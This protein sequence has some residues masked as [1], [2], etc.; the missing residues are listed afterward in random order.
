[1]R[2]NRVVIALLWITLALAAC[3]GARA[4]PATPAPAATPPIGGLRAAS[5]LTL[6]MLKATP[7]LPWLLGMDAP[8]TY[9]ILVQNNDEL[10]ATGGFLSAVGTLGIDR[11]RPGDV[12]FVDSYTVARDDVEHPWAPDPMRKY[13]GIDLMFVRDANWSPDLP[14]TGQ[15]VKALY[16]QDAGVLV[17]G[18][19]T[20][21]MN[22]V[23]LL[24]DALGPLQIEG[25]DEPITGDNLIEQVVQ[26]WDRPVETGTIAEAGLENWWQQRKDFMP[27]LAKAALERLR[28]GDVSPL[29]LAA[30]A[31]QA[32]D[33]RSI[34]VWIDD[35]VV[36]D[37]LAD[38]YWDGAIAPAAG[39]DFLALVDTNVGYNKVDAV[40][41]RSLDYRVTWPDGSAAPAVAQATVT[42]RHPIQ[43]PGY[44]C[45]PSPRYGDN[46]E[47]MTRR[48]Y[49]DYVRLY[50]PAGSE[51]IAVDG[52]ASDSVTSER[53]DHNTQVF[54]GYF[55]L[56]PGY[57][58]SVQFTYRL[59]PEIT[60][61]DY[62][63]VVQRQ[64]GLEALP[65]TLTAGEE[66]LATEMATSRLEWSP[67][68]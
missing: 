10:R 54:G 44:V 9:L 25:A 53:A 55:T 63:L 11:G 39:S 24:I 52:V 48:C 8:R 64:S 19:I 59:P 30:A 41:D 42:Y 31:Y 5:R 26:F 20:I 37:I 21:D 40:L 7:K 56:L 33:Q 65:V 17:D 23:R 58:H 57:Q 60:P 22:A 3:A 36:G 6:P 47:D 32:L 66:S 1:M 27:A 28:S 18:V 50:V 2:K 49:F 61:A 67:A 15:L 45:D 51:L 13:M 4:D 68:R 12:D 38:E 46:Y 16:A 34:Q 62:A 14:T 43:M 29:A 35:P